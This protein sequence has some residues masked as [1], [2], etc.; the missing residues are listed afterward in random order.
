MF[1]ARNARKVS[2]LRPQVLS[3]YRD[4]LRVI[5]KFQPNHQQYWYDY[6]RLK[7][8]ENADVTDEKR[9]KLLMAEARES[10]EWTKSIIVAKEN[11][12]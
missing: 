1:R 10:I 11:K 6:L 7:M 3:L 2:K 9:I 5:Q 12:S 8:A 4:A